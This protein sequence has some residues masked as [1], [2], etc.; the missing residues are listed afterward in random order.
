MS[1]RT[2]RREFMKVAGAGATAMRLAA[3]GRAGA[4]GAAPKRAFRISLAGWSLHR[5]VGEG[6]VGELW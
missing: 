6:S 2:S 1:D 3:A 5:S 4:V